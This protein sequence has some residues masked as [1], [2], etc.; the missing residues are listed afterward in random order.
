MSR[1]TAAR[2]KRS[3]RWVAR[4]A[5]CVA[6]GTAVLTAVPSMARA[7]TETPPPPAPAVP[8]ELTQLISDAMAAASAD[9]TFIVARCLWDEAAHQS[10]HF[11]AGTFDLDGAVEGFTACFT[12]PVPKGTSSTS[13]PREGISTVTP[14]RSADLPT[15]ARVV[16]PTGGTV[17]SGF[18]PRWGA[19]HN[20]IDIAN[21][22]GTPI[23]AVASGTVISAGPAD[24]FGLWVRIRHDDGTITVYGHNDTNRVTV[25]QRVQ[26]NQI[27]ATVGSRG[28]STGPHVHFEVWPANNGP[29][30]P[31]VWLRERGVRI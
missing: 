9:P 15:S 13:T 1:P 16:A 3:R 7:A 10:D 18:G 14:T 2:P 29:V 12:R 24:G 22:T 23:V 6:A 19:N 4:A 28:N 31:A 26:T 11:R 30:D 17:T 27:I 25:G 21:L 20:G 8:A 5:L